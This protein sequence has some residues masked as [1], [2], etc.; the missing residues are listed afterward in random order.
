MLELTCSEFQQ[1]AQDS[2]MVHWLASLSPVAYN[3][4]G[5]LLRD[6]TDGT[7]AYMLRDVYLNTRAYERENNLAEKRNGDATTDESRRRRSGERQSASR[8]GSGA[9]QEGAGQE[10]DAAR[11]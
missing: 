7:R 6:V 4:I 2:E 8:T 11:G 10:G 1:V 9:T 5:N 3:N